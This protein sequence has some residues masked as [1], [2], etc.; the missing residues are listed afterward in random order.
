MS[1]QY[2]ANQ[3]K[4]TSVA[5]ANRGQILI[6]LYEA[7][8]RHTKRATECIEK[9][10]VPGK[11]AAIGKVHDIITELVTTLDFNQGGEV[12]RE[13]ERLYNFIAEQLLKANMENSTEKLK[14]VQRILE[15]LLDGWRGAVE[16]VNKGAS[17]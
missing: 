13:L 16:Q 5:T 1:K 7:A 14:S 17:K 3:Y 8:I 2:G 9:K 15:T 12:A 6:M 11:G 4:T 10:N